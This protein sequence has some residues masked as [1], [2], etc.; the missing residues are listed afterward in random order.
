MTRDAFIA[1]TRFGLGARPG[2]LAQA[3][4]DP[5]GWLKRQIAAAPDTL[6][7]FAGFASG[8]DQ[9]HEFMRARQLR[10]DAGQQK[11]LRASFRETY[12]AETSA[13]LRV[14]VDSQQPLRERLV[15]FWSNHFTVSVQRPPVFGLAGAFEREAIRPHITGSFFN[16]LLAATSHPAML[17]YLDNGQSIGPNSVAGLRRGRGLNENLAREIMELHTLGVDGG[18]SQTDVREFAKILTGWTVGRLEDPRPGYFNFFPRIHEPGVKTVLGVR[19]TERGPEEGEA[20]LQ[21]FA[22]HPATARH[23]ATKLARHFI[24]DDPPPAAVKRLAGIFLATDGN[25][26]AVTEALVEQPE[27]WADPLA[28]VKNPNDFVVA[29]LRATGFEGQG[30]MVLGALRMLGQPPFAAPSP[31]GWPDT[32]DQWIGPESVMRRAEWALALGLRVA[33]IRAPDQIFAETIAPVADKTV[34]RAVLR[35]PSKADALAL[36]FASPAFQRR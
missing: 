10:G 13:R 15:A 25:L 23:I 32:A 24:A 35:A 6:N 34:E 16:M 22:R 12:L 4:R 1:V 31:A 3:G 2:E 17:V 19:Y 27:A 7:A 29:A 5:H 9:M 11:L 20:A 33:E 26:R 18:Y 28:K 36:V 14:Q 30:E 8:G 21:A